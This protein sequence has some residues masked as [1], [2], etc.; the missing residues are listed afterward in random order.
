MMEFH[1]SLTN[2]LIQCDGIP[3]AANRSSDCLNSPM[4]FSYPSMVLDFA[5]SSASKYNAWAL[6]KA[7][8]K[9]LIFSLTSSSI[10]AYISVETLE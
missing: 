4:A 6:R 7:V 8:G 1:L 9:S 2:L 5:K 10:L 3:I